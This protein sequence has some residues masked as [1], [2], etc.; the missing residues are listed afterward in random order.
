MCTAPLGST[1]RAPP[2]RANF[3]A[4]DFVTFAESAWWIK[5]VALFVDVGCGLAVACVGAIIQTVFQGIF[6]RLGGGGRW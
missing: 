2:G 3:D 4:W 5:G 6:R 1:E